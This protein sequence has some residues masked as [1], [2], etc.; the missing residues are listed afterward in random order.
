MQENSQRITIDFAETTI[1]IPDHFKLTSS[2][3]L[4]KDLLRLDEAD[5]IIRTSIQNIEKIE[6]MPMDF[7]IYA[8]TANFENNISFQEGEYVSLTKSISQQ[9]LG[10]LEK[11]L[12]QT[13]ASQGIEFERIESK[14]ISSESKKIIKIKFKLTHGDFSRFT[15][16]YIA[17]AKSNTVG[18]IVNSLSSEDYEILIKGMKIE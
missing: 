13:W 7:I 12:S 1:N 6:S 11:Q 10:M 16:Q 17:S 8:D 5:Y 4:K 15:T 18:M 2:S 3:L 9:Y 14:F